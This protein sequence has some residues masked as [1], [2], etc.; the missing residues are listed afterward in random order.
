MKLQF[1]VLLV[2]GIV[3]CVVG[4]VPKQT[5]KPLENFVQVGLEPG[6]TITAITHSGETHKF[7]IKEIRGDILIGEDIQL[8]L[9]NLKSIEKHAWS[10]PKSPCGGEKPL[11]CSIPLLVS[12]ASD[13]HNHY[14]GTFYNA[15][16]QHDYCYRH[17]KATYGTNRESCDDEFLLDMQ[18]LCPDAA[19]SKIGK[20]LQ[21]LDDSV[22]SRRT[23]LSV[24]K[25]FYSAV[26]RYGEDKYQTTNSSYCEYNGPPPCPVS[27]PQTAPPA[28]N[29]Q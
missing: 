11:G 19:G 29:P 12:L 13:S 7:E 21:T 10:K 18:N 4:C 3:A 23:C 6:D 26:S 15:C 28:E 1:R 14:N 24:A 16:A 5:I 8:V 25:D 20:V 27:A 2:A 17:G 22:G 9:K